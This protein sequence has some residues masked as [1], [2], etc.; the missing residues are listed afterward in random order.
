M[1]ISDVLG[2]ASLSRPG[3][4]T[5][6]TR[7][8]S[9]YDGQLIYETDTDRVASYNGSAWVYLTGTSF[10]EWTSWTPSFTNITQGNGT[11]IARYARIG[12]TVN[13]YFR[14]T[15]GSTTSFSAD[16]TF[17][18]PVTPNGNTNGQYVGTGRLLD[19]GTANYFV[20]GEMNTTFGI[21]I[22]TLNVGGTYPTITA[23]SG[24]VP[25]TFTANDDV[26]IKFVY[27]AA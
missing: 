10:V 27:E 22:K 12:N 26:L 15:W 4:C 5:S 19:T 2:A 20:I 14:L 18:V 25:F 13:G 21:T 23:I 11:V 3:V 6:T 8:A 16:P 17:Q 24:T 1:P 7:P 9:P